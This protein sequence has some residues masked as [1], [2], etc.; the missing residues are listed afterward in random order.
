[1]GRWGDSLNKGSDLF[2]LKNWAMYYWRSKESLHL[3]M[4]SDSFFCS[5]LKKEKLNVEGGLRKF[6]GKHVQLKRW[7][8]G[9]D[10][11]KNIQVKVF[12]AVGK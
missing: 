12:A 10:C 4:M 9:A 1:M 2:S 7:S 6:E 5:S 8:P 11:F 3:A